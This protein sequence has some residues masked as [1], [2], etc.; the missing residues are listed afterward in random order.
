[1]SARRRLTRVGLSLFPALLIVLFLG[2]GGAAAMGS[3][4]AQV[5]VEIGD[6]FFRPETVTVNV[7]DTVVWTHRGNQPHNV[8][9]TTGAFESELQMRNGQQFTY[10]PTAPGT[11][12]YV[13]TIHEGMDGT[14]IVQ[15]AGA[16][17]Q[18][19]TT[20]RTT[21]RTTALTTTPRTTARTTAMTTTPRT[22]TAMRTTARTTTMAALPRTGGGGM[23]EQSAPLLWATGA[24]LLALTAAGAAYAL[25]R[26]QI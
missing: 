11:Y 3:G 24:G 7:G 6:N 18:M 26:R 23:G 16:G 25:R 8:T 4:A 5:D 20:A 9:S 10:T 13:C 1:M 12:E 21:A 2:L 22:T 15:A 17:G 14:L 19:T